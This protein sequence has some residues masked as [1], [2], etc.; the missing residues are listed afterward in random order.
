MANEYLDLSS[1]PS[2]L[3]RIF[4]SLGFASKGDLIRLTP[5]TGGVSSG[6]YRVDLPSETYCL[7]QALPQLKV[8][9]EWK[10]PVE[11]VFT[12]IE[13]L[14]VAGEIAPGSIPKVLGTDVATKS[15]V[16]EYLPNNFVVWKNELLSGRIN[17]EIAKQVG[18]LVG[19]IHVAT[20]N[21]VSISERFATDENF[22]A[23]RLEPYLAEIGRVHPDFSSY[24]QILIERTQNNK[25]ALV[26]G[27]LSP[28]NILIG[29]NGPVLIDAECA[30]YGDPAFDMAFCLNHLVLKAIWLPKYRAELIASFGAMIETYFA[31]ADFE[32]RSELEARIST[33]LP[34][35]MLARV[36]GKSPVEYLDEKTRTSVRNTA[37]ALLSNPVHRLKEFQEKFAKEYKI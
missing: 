22:Y 26:H 29:P 28:K 7:K 18:T 13:W 12:E 36:D 30:W 11:R 25:I 27:D 14:R 33:L 9:K 35:L 34:A 16:M 3:S 32:P 8:A 15:F 19:R 17:I 4:T 5:L 6:I 2:E 31:S 23:I 24:L 20:A 1:S 21:S 37:F 10:V